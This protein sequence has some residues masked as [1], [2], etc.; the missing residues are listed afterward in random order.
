MGPG[1]ITLEP[2]KFEA[3]LREERAESVLSD[4]ASNAPRGDVAEQYTKFAKTIV[5]VEPGDPAD[6]TYSFP[7]GHRLEIIPLSNPLTWR[8]RRNCWP[9]RRLARRISCR[10][11]ASNSLPSK[12]RAAKPPGFLISIE[13]LLPP[14][15]QQFF[16]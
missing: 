3:Y 7:L 12:N 9:S 16:V 13:W 11:A 5:A 6:T 2:A 8:A 10:A 4:S 15:A 1:Y 14:I